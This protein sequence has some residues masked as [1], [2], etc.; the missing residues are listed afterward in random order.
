MDCSVYG[1]SVVTL[2]GFGAKA[3]LGHHPG[4]ATVFPK[5]NAMSIDESE[6]Y[7]QRHGPP[8]T[9]PSQNSSNGCCGCAKPN[10]VDSPGSVDVVR[11]WFKTMAVR[12]DEHGRTSKV[13][14]GANYCIPSIAAPTLGLCKTD[15]VR[16]AGAYGA[17]T[18]IARAVPLEKEAVVAVVVDPY[19]ATIH[20]HCCIILAK[21]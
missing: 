10:E 21:Q 13:T 18:R 17:P 2:T 9:E 7:R 14:M 11:S 15:Q 5:R 4:F 19:R 12:R 6:L 20:R 8:W 16:V 3:L 1:S